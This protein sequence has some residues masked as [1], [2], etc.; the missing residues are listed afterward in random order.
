M[1]REKAAAASAPRRP[2]RGGA[3]AKVRLNNLV[4]KTVRRSLLAGDILYA[5]SQ[6]PDGSFE[7]SV[8][9]A[10]LEGGEA[11]EFTGTGPDQPSAER[12]AAAAA[13]AAL[14][15]APAYEPRYARPEAAAKWV[16]R[17]LEA[18]GEPVEIDSTMAD[19][20]PTLASLPDGLRARARYVLENEDPCRV[21]IIRGGEEE[22]QSG[23]VRTMQVSGRT[24]SG[25]LAAAMRA[26]LLG[27]SGEPP[28]GR[29]ELRLAGRSAAK[30][31]AIAVK[32]LQRFLPPPA[33]ER[34]HF[35]VRAEHF[36]GYR[37]QGLV[38]SVAAS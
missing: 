2:S 7:A 16:A 8:R 38:V 37:K 23:E 10:A 32:I 31:A 19:L 15:P 30:E 28:C 24:L 33:Q 1:R 21:S 4:S 22:P 34:L 13:L 29:L 9:V 17:E 26:R 12:R 36:E 14:P 11:L 25:K 35:H 3:N 20:L 5:S 27:E 18:T 6:L